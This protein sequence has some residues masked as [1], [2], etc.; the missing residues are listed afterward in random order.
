MATTHEPIK[1]LARRGGERR[2]ERVGGVQYAVKYRICLP[3]IFAECTLFERE[4]EENYL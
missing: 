3:C 4:D 1:I 2:G